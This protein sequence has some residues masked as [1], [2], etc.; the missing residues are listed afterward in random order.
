MS[1]VDGYKGYVLDITHNLTGHF[2]AA[3][4]VQY[5]GSNLDVYINPDLYFTIYA[6]QLSQYTDVN[7]GAIVMTV[8]KEYNM[9]KCPNGR[10]GDDLE[11]EA[12]S[13]GIPNSY[14]CINGTEFY[15]LQGY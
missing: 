15:Q 12:M 13:L 4:Q 10:F 5:A 1:S 6:Q 14:Q 3:F 7:T 8:E 9:M 11:A 2:D